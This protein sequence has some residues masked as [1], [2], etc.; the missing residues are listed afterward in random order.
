MKTVGTSA[1]TT[2]QEEELMR[3]QRR[4]HA[5]RALTTS[6]LALA[7]V[8][9]TVVAGPAAP[10]LASAGD[11]L[12]TPAMGWNSFNSFRLDVT[13]ALVKQT[14][15]KLVSTGLAAA[16]Y[17]Y[18]NMDGGW[19]QTTRTSTGQLQ[20]KTAA[21]PSGIP[22]L[23]AYVH[24]RGLKFGAYLHVGCSSAASTTVGHEADD[25]ALLA[26]W[27]VDFL[28]VDSCGQLS[29]N[30]QAIDV[31]YQKIRDAIDASG[32]DIVLSIATNGAGQPY[33][34]FGAQYGDMWRTTYDIK[35]CWRSCS[36]GNGVLDIVDENEPLAPYAGDGQWNDPDMLEVGV[37]ARE[38]SYGLS[39]DQAR[40]HMGMWAVF[41]APLIIGADLR[42]ANQTTLRILGNTEVIAV[43]QDPLGVQGRRVGAAGDLEVYSK[44]LADG[45]RAVVLLNRSTTDAA[46]TAGFASLGLSGSVAVRD[47][48]A[49]QSRGVFTG[50]YSAWVPANGSV[51]LRLTPGAS[52]GAPGPA[53][54][55]PHQVVVDNTD[56]G[57]TTTGTWTS[58]TTSAVGANIL[59][60]SYLRTTS[61]SDTTSTATYQLTADQAGLWNVDL[62]WVGFDNRS[63][64]VTVTLTTS[65]VSQTY[66]ID[67]RMYGGGWFTLRNLT[68]ASGAT[69]TLTTTAGGGGYTIADGARL[70]RS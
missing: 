48:W 31:T 4:E 5:R 21:F 64:A 27:G 24:D 50:G 68:L 51:M 62:R 10:A 15:D 17:E 60:T 30:G 53:A 13:E 57:F 43:D 14:A 25:V 69:V 32:R 26:S 59:G 12:D 52:G 45:S 7:L 11:V 63:A 38:G 8:F 65:G 33:S 47:L 29:F 70:V 35:P 34:T 36:V 22:A 41:A 46:M 54:S 56:P 40:A 3:T 6:G 44:P 49:K 66:T 37:A 2:R 19:S 58:S 16:G 20:A 55:A 1:D 61:S 9:G 28:K 67:Q 42:T 39:A 18:V 23:A